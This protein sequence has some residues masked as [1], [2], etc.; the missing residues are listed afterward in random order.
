MNRSNTAEGRQ[1]CLPHMAAKPLG[2]GWGRR[3]RL[4]ADSFTSSE[5]LPN[6]AFQ[7][8]Q[9][10]D[11]RPRRGVSASSRTVQEQFHQAVA[12]VVYL[13]ADIGSVREGWISGALIRRGWPNGKAR[14]AG[15]VSVLV[16][17]QKLFLPGRSGRMKGWSSVN[18]SMAASTGA[19]AV[20]NYAIR[21]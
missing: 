5:A 21:R 18:F 19:F 9:D 2:G 1:H 12:V 3:F 17:G 7:H 4:P 13:M 16:L 10:V 15:A 14:K 8:Y 6:R 20:H 11:I